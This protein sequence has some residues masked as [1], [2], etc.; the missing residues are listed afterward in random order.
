MLVAFK[1]AP[2]SRPLYKQGALDMLAFPQGWKLTLSYREKWVDESLRVP[3]RNDLLR[4]EKVLVV[5]CGNVDS[6]THEFGASIPLRWAI[7]EETGTR[8]RQDAGVLYLL[9]RLEDR[10]NNPVVTNFQAEMQSHVA[11]PRANEGAFVAR[12]DGESRDG[13]AM[14]WDEHVSNVR[15]IRE[16]KDSLFFRVTGLRERQSGKAATID[17]LPS[18]T[19]GVDFRSATLYE[20]ELYV[21]GESL[22]G[23]GVP[24]ELLME[25]Q[26]LEIAEP[27]LLQ[28]GTGAIVT[29]LLV[30]KRK[31][32]SDLATLVVRPTDPNKSGAEVRLLIR[33]GPH[34]AFW[35]L[36]MLGLVGGWLLTQIDGTIVSGLESKP[37]ILM[38]L[39]LLGAIIIAATGWGAFRRLPIKL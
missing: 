15:R 38:G 39:K 35:P 5:L 21:H 26:H 33:M 22:S 30:V 3:L 37:L 8:T 13:S 12:L 27:L 11:V 23:R 29:Y 1:T 31:Y 9:L 6:V 2:E 7:V 28:H 17:R 36:T 20:L 14:P 10:P 18:Q 24:L 34:W 32:T 25:G 16:V 19:T 4:G